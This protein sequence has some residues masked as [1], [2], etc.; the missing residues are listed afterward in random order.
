MRASRGSI[1]VASVAMLVACGGS[2]GPPPVT[3]GVVGPTTLDAGTAPVASA[4]DAGS[5]GSASAGDDPAK[6]AGSQDAVLQRLSAAWA[7]DDDLGASGNKPADD[8]A[9]CPKAAHD[10]R[11]ASR[12]LV[13]ASFV[14][15][16]GIAT[17]A[18]DAV[19]WVFLGCTAARDATSCESWRERLVLEPVGAEPARVLGDLE[20]HMGANAG[21]L[22]VP[23]AF[24]RDDGRILARAW[25][26]PP[27]A[28]GG[29]VDYGVGSIARST[30]SREEPLPVA[31][32]AAR[33]PTFYAG[34]GC[35]VG[36]AESPKTPTYSQP[37]SPSNNGGALV[38]IDL[39]TMRRRTLLESPDTTYAVKGVDEK[40]GSLE[41][42]VTHHTFGKDCPRGEGALNCSAGT[43]TKRRI[44][45]PA[46]GPSGRSAKG[47]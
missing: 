7:R 27:G 43:T 3:A 17:H 39:A 35:A 38:V 22:F 19:L 42:E 31:P 13:P 1:V 36:L 45:L 18:C 28:G 6:D 14:R 47:P 11:P 12:A 25:M 24:T 10:I 9:R 37:G 44:A 40:A 34:D 32:L 30:Q 46:C 8:L 21:G 33:D 16:V 5:P 29:A 20:P 26:F 23:F 4:P 2:D 15:F 41:V